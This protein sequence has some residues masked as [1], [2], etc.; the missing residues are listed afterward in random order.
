MRARF[1]SC[2]ATTRCST[3]S[4]AMSWI[5]VTTFSC[6]IR[7]AR[8]SPAPRRPDHVNGFCTLTPVFSKSLVFLVTTVSPCL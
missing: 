6:P 2:M 5:E 1:F 7:W 8:S 4:R 3:V